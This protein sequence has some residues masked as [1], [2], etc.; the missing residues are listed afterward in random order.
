[1]GAFHHSRL[2]VYRLAVQFARGIDP[3]LRRV[4]RWRA[5]V[6]DQLLRATC[7]ILANI[8]EGAGEHSPRDKARFYRIARRSAT[9]C[10]A[11]L[12]FLHVADVA[13]AEEA[14]AHQ[15]LL[16][17]IA[18]LLTTMARRLEAPQSSGGAAAA[19]PRGR[20][21]APEPRRA[22]RRAGA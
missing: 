2:D 10:A 6:R 14:Q 22:A 11:L 3:I 19:E 15:R 20:A 8:A 1:M 9:E 17:R 13:A 21:A 7:S 18:A 12:D 4:P 16:A 5:P